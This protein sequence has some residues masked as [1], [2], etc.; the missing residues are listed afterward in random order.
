MSQ[1]QGVLTMLNARLADGH[2]GYL[3]LPPEYALHV[4]IFGVA[5]VRQ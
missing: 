2:G 1:L 4:R 3:E 5:M